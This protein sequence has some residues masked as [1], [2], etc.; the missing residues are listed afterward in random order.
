MGCSEDAKEAVVEE[1]IY[2]GIVERNNLNE[3]DKG[4]RMKEDLIR[5]YHNITPNQLRKFNRKYGDE[6][7]ELY[8]KASENCLYEYVNAAEKNSI[9]EDMLDYMKSI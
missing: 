3:Q 8:S 1:S 7:G 6:Y 9:L 4:Y 5:Y 2:E